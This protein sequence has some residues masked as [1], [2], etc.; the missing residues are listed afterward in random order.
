MMFRIEAGESSNR[1]DL[2][3]VREETGFPVSTWTRMISLRIARLRVSRLL[4]TLEFGTPV[5]G[6]PDQGTGPSKDSQEI[7]WP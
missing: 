4:M 3:S 7:D 5:R 2:K 1:W 6:V